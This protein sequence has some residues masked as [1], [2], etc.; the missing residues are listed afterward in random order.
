MSAQLLARCAIGSAAYLEASMLRR[1]ADDK[2]SGV[3]LRVAK[4]GGLRAPAAAPATEAP[5]SRVAAP[6]EATS[7]CE[8]SAI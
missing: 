8:Q 3:E 2:V 7:I 6:A 1:S 5:V 4:S